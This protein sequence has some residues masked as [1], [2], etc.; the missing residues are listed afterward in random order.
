MFALIDMASGWSQVWGAISSALGSSGT[1][2][3]TAIGVLIAVFSTVV[4]LWERR[5]GN[6]GGH[7][8]LLYSL[9]FGALLMGPVIVIPIVLTIADYAVNA[10]LNIGSL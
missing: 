5:K 9:L 10:V 4:W 2:L 1:T 3:M 7:H 6:G 8:K